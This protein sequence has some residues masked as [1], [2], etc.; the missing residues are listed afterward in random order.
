[1]ATIDAPTVQRTGP[2]RVLDCHGCDGAGYPTCPVCH[3]TGRLVRD[4]HPFVTLESLMEHVGGLQ[5][6]LGIP[7]ADLY[8]DGC[9]GAVPP[10]RPGTPAYHL[11]AVAESAASLFQQL[12]LLLPEEWER[13]EG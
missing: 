3:G 1:M 12:V 6:A 5:T 4:L 8:G 10:S 7:F 2:A 9:G 13:T 11:R